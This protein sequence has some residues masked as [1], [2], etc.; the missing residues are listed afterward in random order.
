MVEA[1]RSTWALFL[2]LGLIMLGNGLQGSLVSIR[3]QFE[4][5]DNTT[6]GLIMGGYFFGFF[7]GSIIVP[8]LVGRVG[9]VRVFGAL[10]SLSSLV[11]L[12]FPIFVEPWVWVLMRVITGLSYAGLYIVVESWLNDRAGNENRGQLLAIYMLVSSLGMGAGP[13][14]LNIHSPADFQLFTLVS[15]LVSLAVIPVLVSAAKTPDFSAPTTISLRKLYGISPLGLFGMLLVGLGAGAMMGMGPVYVYQFGLTVADASY[16]MSGIFVGVFVMTWPLGHFSDRF[17][18]RTVI[19]TVSTISAG[20]AFACMFIP[21]SMSIL[22][23]LSGLVVGGFLFPLY[24]M[25]IA[26]TNDFLEPNQMVAA[27]ATLVMANGLGAML[28]PSLTGYAMDLFGPPGFFL[29]VAAS[30]GLIAA[31]AVWRMTRRMAVPVG[32]QGHFV[33]MTTSAMGVALNPEAEYEEYGFSVLEEHGDTDD[34]ERTVDPDRF[35]SVIEVE[36]DHDPLIDK[37]PPTP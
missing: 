24:S 19:A 13:L 35:D 8:K 7:L 15:A 11:I 16:F 36:E 23:L 5:F 2:G 25:C 34:P 31:F 3:A 14:L 9:H 21:G 17:D 22:V 30:A 20:I 32:E 6:T 1:L 10:A 28:G 4:V 18:R 26:H 37:P 12:V 33:P 27:S 29:T